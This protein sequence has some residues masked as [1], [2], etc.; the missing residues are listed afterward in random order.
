MC[1]VYILYTPVQSRC[2]YVYTLTYTTTLFSNPPHSYMNIL[3]IIY[4]PNILLHYYGKYFDIITVVRVLRTI[5]LVFSYLL[6]AVFYFFFFILRLIG[7][8]YLL[9]QTNI[10]YTYIYK[11]FVHSHP[12]SYTHI[13]GT[14]LFLITII[15]L[16]S[17]LL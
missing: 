4:P 17:T 16:C 8:Y 13:L 6:T 12:N 11:P 10:L 14:L 7:M 15:L 9:I 3:L 2:D 5:V 1:R